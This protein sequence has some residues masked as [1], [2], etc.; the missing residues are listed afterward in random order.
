MRN[1]NVLK[2]M[3]IIAAASASI[4][5]LINNLPKAYGMFGKTEDEYILLSSQYENMFDNIRNKK[6]YENE[7][8]DLMQR[9]SS[10]NVKE[11][12]RQE[13]VLGNLDEILSGCDIEAFEILF[14]QPQIIH[15]GGEELNENTSNEARKV[16]VNLKFTS[17]YVNVL[18]FMDAIQESQMGFTVEKVQLNMDEND[19]FGEANL[20]FYVLTMDEYYE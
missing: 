8:S 16:S 17:N 5:M 3:F 6:N 7:M 2:L 1:N 9:I 15:V 14:S 20:C 13:Q 12:I 4:F 10:L 11:D 19:V 18:K